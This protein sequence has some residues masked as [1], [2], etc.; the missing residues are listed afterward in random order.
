MKENKIGDKLCTIIGKIWSNRLKTVKNVNYAQTEQILVEAG[1]IAS[2]DK[3]NA[4]I[5]QRALAES[6]LT[7]EQQK[8]I[9]TKLELIDVETGEVITTNA[10]TK[11]DLEA[12]LAKK[13]IVGADAEA[14][15]SSMGL[16]SANATQT[17]SFDLL[18]ASI[19]T[20]TINSPSINYSPLYYIIAQKRNIV[21]N[22]RTNT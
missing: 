20:Y 12:T 16:T 21:N 18:T 7:A 9:L 17:I 13:G 1:I 10:C 15:I 6:T 2:N 11:A 8:D 19:N 14:I 22:L 5:V 4:S 3:I